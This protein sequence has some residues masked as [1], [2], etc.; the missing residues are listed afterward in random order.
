MAGAGADHSAGAHLG[1]GAV[2]ARA[3][4]WDGTAGILRTGADLI[5]T[6]ADITVVTDITVMAITETMHR[7]TE[8][9]QQTVMASP[10]EVQAS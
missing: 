6:G 3:G 2:T 10:T 8:E 9:V 4:D 7:F 1:L 5:L